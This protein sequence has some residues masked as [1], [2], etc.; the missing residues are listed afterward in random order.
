MGTL[1]LHVGKEE[2]EQKSEGWKRRGCVRFRGGI[3]I[4]TQVFGCVCW[5]FGMTSCLYV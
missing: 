4:T 5:I 1:I 3:C 2:E